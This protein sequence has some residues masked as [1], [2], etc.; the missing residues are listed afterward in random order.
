MIKHH[1]SDALLAQYCNASLPASLSVAVAIHLEMCECCHAKVKRL[2]AQNAELIF[3]QPQSAIDEELSADAMSLLAAITENDDVDDV[4]EV[5]P[6]TVA[7]T[8]QYS[9]QLPRALARIPHS[10]FM[11]LGKISRSRI[12]LEDGA[13]RSSLLHIAAGG[14]IPEHTHTG[15]ELTLLLDGEFSDEEGDYVAGDFMWLDGRH[16]HTPITKDG[17][18]CYTVVSSALHFN[19]GL[20]KLLNPIGSLIY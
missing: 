12:G 15:F 2:E 4:Y 8:K 11:Q 9:Y 17:C 16:Q 3:A 5:Q 6:Q 20:S 14:E 1:P 18:L 10:K 13:L 7:I 19:K